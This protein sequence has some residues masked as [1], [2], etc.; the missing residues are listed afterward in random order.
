[1]KTTNINKAV[2]SE[3]T[4]ATEQT[5]NNKKR[6]II[7]VTAASVVLVAIIV[8]ILLLVGCNDVDSTATPDEATTVPTVAT[9]DEAATLATLSDKDQAIVDNGLTVNEDGDIVDKDG[10]KVEPSEDGKVTIKDA[11]GKEIKV[12]TDSV[13]T[14]NTNKTYVEIT[15]AIIQSANNNSSNNSGSGNSSNASSNKN[16]SSSGSNSSKNNSSNSSSN[17]NNGSSGNSS[18][19]SNTNK[20][21]NSS[22][23]G[24]SSSNSTANDPH[25]GKTYH[26]AE[27]KTIH[28]EAETEQVWVVDQEAY[29]YEE[30]IYEYKTVSICKD[31]GA[32]L[33]YMSE[34]ELIVHIREHTL[35]GGKGGWYTEVREI[36]T[37]TK[38]V[39][40]P[41]KGHYETKIVKEA[42]DEKV[43]VRE[44]GWY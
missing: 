14:A 4:I 3:Q 13:K 21:N 37:G 23:G 10:K 2:N 1:M 35:N 44:A 12:D 28:H 38:T 11:N 27:Y 6:N 15:N 39:N 20:N 19:S 40:V 34:Q 31:C 7:L 24:S 25:A 32:I 36:E 16:N 17:K 41:E 5:A 26:E 22:S 43:L 30:P 8:L 9:A 18:S 33:S 29:S 42:Y